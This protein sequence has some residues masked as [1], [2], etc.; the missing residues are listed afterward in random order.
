MLLDA[1][2]KERLEALGIADLDV[3]V[4]TL[5]ERIDASTLVAL[6]LKELGIAKIVTKAGSD[7]PRQAAGA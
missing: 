5:G 4:V 3:A 6:H 7:R 1:R 2:E